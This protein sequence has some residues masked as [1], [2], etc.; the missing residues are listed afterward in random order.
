MPPPAAEFDGVEHVASSSDAIRP[1]AF[2]RRLTADTLSSLRR[3]RTGAGRA[4]RK[5]LRSHRREGD[6]GSD[7]ASSDDDDGS[8]DDDLDDVTCFEVFCCCWGPRCCVGSCMFIMTLMGWSAAITYGILKQPTYE[9]VVTPIR[10]ARQRWFTKTPTT[11]EDGFTLFD[12]N[13]DGRIT[14][15]DMAAVARITTGEYPTHEQLAAYIAKGDMD[16]DGALDEQEY[17]QL[18]HRE[19]AEKASEKGVT[20]DGLRHDVA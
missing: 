12:R 2:P 10:V 8:D 13:A 9:S 19:R 5:P 20:N 18:L 11:A 3:R 6:D 7:A 4:V 15:Q 1:S 14:V 16:G 17:L